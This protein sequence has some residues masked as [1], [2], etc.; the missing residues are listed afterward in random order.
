MHAFQLR[1]YTSGLPLFFGPGF[2]REF[3]PYSSFLLPVD[4]AACVPYSGIGQ[5]RPPGFDSPSCRAVGSDYNPSASAPQRILVPS[6]L[7]TIRRPVF[8]VKETG[9]V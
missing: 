6:N 1:R 8:P 9:I 7:K 4:P 5:H 2:M 3:P